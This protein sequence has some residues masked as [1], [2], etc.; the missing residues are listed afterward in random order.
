MRVFEEF[1]EP[2]Y[3]L[4]EAKYSSKQPKATK[5]LVNRVEPF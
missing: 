3:E 5:R 2:F 4:H 1:K